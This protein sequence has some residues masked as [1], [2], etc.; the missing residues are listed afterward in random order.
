M[1]FPLSSGL[2]LAK[3]CSDRM[4]W[5]AALALTVALCAPGQGQVTNLPTELSFLSTFGH[6][7]EFSPYKS[8]DKA[9]FPR[10]GGGDNQVDKFGRRWRLWVEIPGP[11]VGDDD[12]VLSKVK[13]PAL[14]AGWTIVW[15]DT[16]RTG[17]VEF[18]Y[19]KNGVEAWA[20]VNASFAFGTPHANWEA[21]EIT[22]PPISVTLVEPS[23][24]PEKMPTGTKGDFPF[25]TP[26][27]KSTEYGGQD[28]N[29]PWSVKWKDAKDA[30]IVATGSISRF[31]KY[32]DISDIL[33]GTV[34]HDALIKA[35][36][37]VD[38]RAPDQPILAHYSKNGRNLW[39]YVNLGGDAYVIQVGKE[40]AP[41]QLKRSLTT[42]CHVAL[43]GVLFDFNKSTL[44]PASDG[45]LQQVA[46]LMTANAS[47]KIEVQGHT[48]NVGGDAYNQSL[49][50]ARA[51]SVMEW[52]SAHGVAAARMTAKGYGKTMPVADNNTDD[53]RAK[54]RRV[55][56][57][58]PSCKRK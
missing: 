52:L 22:P 39:A 55:E 32:P 8:W 48:D 45:V 42:D 40:G 7:R 20:K 26:I 33:F 38:Q 18:H 17:I 4:H 34:Y 47:L 28:S 23:A 3:L 58:D 49:S 19:Q 57:A 30:D 5:L 1:A 37:D 29:D 14:Q 56:I 12:G 44:Q 27:P 36:W 11:K 10:G 35:G 41:D 31:Y 43:Y 46:N 24:T 15:D 25:L 53:G 6:V 54:N 51:H 2:V 21:V 13:P 9:T 50:E 16:K